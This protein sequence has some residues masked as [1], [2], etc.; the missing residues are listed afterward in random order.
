MIVKYRIELISSSRNKNI[1]SRKGLLEC[2]YDCYLSR[3]MMI[4]IERSEDKT[5][6][7][8]SD[9]RDV[10]TKDDRIRMT[11]RYIRFNKRREIYDIELMEVC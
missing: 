7:D 8:R 2:K 6:D 3:T 9:R 1:V 11:V 5:K 4:V 10:K